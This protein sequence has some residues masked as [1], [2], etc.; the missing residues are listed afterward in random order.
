MGAYPKTLVVAGREIVRTGAQSAT[1]S[2]TEYV[3][4]SWL[5]D[6]IETMPWNQRATF[7]VEAVAIK[8]DSYPP[9]SIEYMGLDYRGEA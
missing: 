7:P 2:G 1:W 3:V 6:H 5:L 4:P 8:V 9:Q